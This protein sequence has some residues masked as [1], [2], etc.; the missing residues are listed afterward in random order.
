MELANTDRLIR[1]YEEFGQSPWLDNLQRG[2]LTSGQL[3]QLRDRGIRGLTS[4]PTIFQKAIAGSADYDE[5]F[6]GLAADANATLDDYWAMVLQDINGAADVLDSVYESSDGVDGYVSVEVN[7]GLAHDGPGTESAARD[8]HERL[9][10]RNVMVKIPATAAGVAT[11]MAAVRQRE[12]VVRKLILVMG[13]SSGSSCV[14]RVW[15]RPDDLLPE[16]PLATL[17]AAQLQVE[18]HL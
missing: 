5:Q 10:R 1:L 7:P 9:G 4:N 13:T 8:L 2:Y 16:A 17:C 18:V 15:S 6:R 3:A 11:V 12:A 14:A